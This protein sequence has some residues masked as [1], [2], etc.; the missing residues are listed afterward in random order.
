[1]T[2]GRTTL[3]SRKW[4]ATTRGE[5]SLR[6]RLAFARDAVVGQL[7]A[8][9]GPR[10]RAAGVA[11]REPP[12]T[13]LVRDVVALAESAYPRALFEHCLRCWWWGSILSTMDELA[14]DDELLYVSCLLHDF[15]LTERYRVGEAHCFAVHGGDIAFAT[16][17][18]YGAPTAFAERAAEAVTA[19]MNVR[20]SSGLGPEAVALQ[21]AAHLD[22]GGTRARELPRAAIERVVARHPRDGFTACFLD[23][24]RT[25]AAQ[26]PHS[27]AAVLWRL[28]MRLP[29]SVNPLDRR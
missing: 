25:E 17:A 14:V 2:A 23:L 29:A 10:A 5:L 12:D 20:V 18:G 13:P 28:G 6:D 9:T 8:L 27:R 26:R 19:H 22:V 1:M 21:A 11:G 16:L 7:S 4:A 15:A 24:M 3:G